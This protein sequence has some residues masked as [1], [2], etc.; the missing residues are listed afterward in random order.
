MNVA[1]WEIAVI[2]VIIVAMFIALIA[3]Y[4]VIVVVVIEKALVFQKDVT[5]I[6]IL[7]K[8]AD[9]LKYLSIIINK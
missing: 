2:Q 1:M 3:I 6:V 8:F 4:I 7:V 5:K 9:N